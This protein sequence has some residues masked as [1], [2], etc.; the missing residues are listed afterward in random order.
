MP[1]R[2]L[3]NWIWPPIVQG[4]LDHFTAEEELACYSP[5]AQQID[6][7]GSVT[8]RSCFAIPVPQAAVNAFRDSIRIA[9]D[10]ALS[11]IP[12]EFDV[13]AGQVYEL[14]GSPE[15]SAETA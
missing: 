6:A 8:E 15:C 7:I 13:V 11:W 9:R 5:A 3:F 12:A 10:D 2:H 1:S 4:E 14:L